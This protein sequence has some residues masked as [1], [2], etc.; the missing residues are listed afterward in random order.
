M[1]SVSLAHSPSPPAADLLAD[2]R[3]AHERLLAA[4]DD[5][6]AA[7]R[8]AEPGGD[9]YPRAR[10]RLSQASRHRRSL[11]D[12]A[13]SELLKRASA[14]DAKAMAALRADGESRLRAS[15]AHVRTWTMERIDSDW[16][17]YCRAS[18]LLRASMRER[19]ASE[20][21]VLYPLLSKYRK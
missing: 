21:T 4:I 9:L 13:C 15:A 16:P 5:M 14:E 7:T 1:P 12:A 2:L 11:V 19:I 6:E 8:A 17:A 3:D 20:K 10:W 18:A